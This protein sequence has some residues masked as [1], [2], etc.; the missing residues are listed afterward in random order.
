MRCPR[1]QYR[2]CVTGIDRESSGF[3][4]PKKGMF[5]I[6]SLGTILI[7]SAVASATAE[8]LVIR[9][10]PKGFTVLSVQRRGQS[11][12][13]R[14]LGTV[15]AANEKAIGLSAQGNY[16]LLTTLPPGRG[17]R[18]RVV[19]LSGKKPRTLLTS[20]VREDAGSAWLS[21]GRLR[22]M[23][24]PGNSATIEL[25]GL[26]VE[27]WSHDGR[28]AFPY[29]GSPGD[30]AQAE[31]DSRMLREHEVDL[32]FLPEQS[33]YGIRSDHLSSGGQARLGWFSRDGSTIVTATRV[34][35]ENGF[36]VLERKGGWRKRLMTE[37]GCY[38]ATSDGTTIALRVWRNEQE[39]AIFRDLKTLHK[40]GEMRCLLVC[41]RGIGRT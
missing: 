28:S 4:P 15:E 35:N 24:A 21:P 37:K 16:L 1:I 8:V 41:S 38:G 29:G 33:G 12:A 2:S 27:S 40:L 26:T 11:I 36:A 34:G 39:W 22:L 10:S 14:L 6:K 3:S 20:T 18:H 19:L 30:V 32:P 17:F 13:T 31:F 7:A 5:G 9:A 23:G 25:P